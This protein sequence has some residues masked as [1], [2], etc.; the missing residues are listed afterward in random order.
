MMKA[1]D[2]SPTL[3]KELLTRRHL[4][5]YE[6]F[7][8]RWRQ[9]SAELE[10]GPPA[11]SRAQFFRWLNGQLKRGAPHPD[12]C[13]VLE[14]MFPGLSA[15]DLFGPPPADAA[16]AQDGWQRPGE[17]DTRDATA[18]DGLLESVP[19]SFPAEVLQ[20]SWATSYTF[21]EPAKRHVDIA[22][23]VAVGG[24][25]DRRLQA[26]NYPPEPRTQAHP[27]PYRNMIDGHLVGR[28]LVGHWRND[29]DARYYGTLQLA[30]LPGENV[31]HGYY[32]GYAS[33]IGVSCGRWVWVRLDPGSLIGVDL[34]RVRLRD[35]GELAGLLDG[36]SQY[37]PPLHL[38]AIV[39]DTV[40]E[41]VED[42]E[43]TVEDTQ[44]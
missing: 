5:R 39:E 29:S 25:G 38:S 22:H 31:L 3:L 20:G 10:L 30:A 4:Q 9:V 36:Y 43:D 27:V 2:D 17:Q 40:E 33:D 19:P 35:P 23:L 32:T 26:V 16:D 28:H 12:A 1:M 21:S 44:A 13:R 41:L 37:D 7:R 24:V 11:P 14:A 8:G 42:T 18:A 15:D 6:T 34:E